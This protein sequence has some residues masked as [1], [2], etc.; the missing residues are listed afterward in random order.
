MKKFENVDLDLEWLNNGKLRV[1]LS[2]FGV[3]AILTREQV[4]QTRD[5][6]TTALRNGP[7]GRSGRRNAVLSARR[8]RR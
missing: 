8:V 3:A 4:E 6:L 5:A 1:E 7:G 2:T